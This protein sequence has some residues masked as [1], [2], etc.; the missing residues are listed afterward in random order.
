MAT[1]DIWSDFFGAST[2]YTGPPLTDAMVASGMRDAGYQ[3]V[4]IDDCWQGPRDANGVITADP[5]RYPSGIK[6]LAGLFP[7][8]TRGRAGGVFNAGAQFGSVIAPPIVEPPKRSAFP[9]LYT[10]ID[11]V[12][13]SSSD[14]KSVKPSAFR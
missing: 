13:R 5:Q 4:V 14:S 11:S 7:A 2:H 12:V 6:A 10:A 8:E 1:A 9:P 3:Y